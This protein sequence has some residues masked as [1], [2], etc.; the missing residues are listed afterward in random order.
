MEWTEHDAM[1]L[2]V[3]ERQALDLDR[4]ERG[5]VEGPALGVLRECRNQR[6][7]LGRLI[8]AGWGA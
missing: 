7:A 2:E 1:L 5:E 3:A 8:G 6:I 4:L